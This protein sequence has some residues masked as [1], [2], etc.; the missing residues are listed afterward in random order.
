MF[1][2]IFTACTAYSYVP[3][4]SQVRYVNPSWGPAYYQGVRYYYLPD[5]E[6]YYDL[7]SQEFIYLNNGQWTYSAY[8]PTIYSGFDLNNCFTIELNANIYQPWMHHQYYV[9]HYPRYYYR[10]YYDHSNI[11]YVRGYNENIRSAVYWPENERSK[12]R[13]WDNSNINSNKQFKYSNSDK[14]HQNKNSNYK[15]GQYNNSNSNSKWNNGSANNQNQNSNKQTDYNQNKNNNSYGNQQ[16]N[17]GNTTNGTSKP[18]GN[19][20]GNTSTAGNNQNQRPTGNTT[21]NNNPSSGN[22]TGTNNKPSTGNTTQ[23]KSENNTGRTPNNNNVTRQTT[24]PTG[25]SRTTQSTNYYG[26]T[27]GQPVKVERQM[28]EGTDTRVKKTT[29]TTK[30]TPATNSGT[31]R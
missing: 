24:E 31:R 9:S 5:I 17:T 13:E 27:I 29:T 3:A 20:N 11:P 23:S 7:S 26:R 22:S 4:E 15:N 6:T 1:V 21:V 16:H 28:K 10:D 14:E 2:S 12:A 18:S 19:Y 8:L 25:T 30:E